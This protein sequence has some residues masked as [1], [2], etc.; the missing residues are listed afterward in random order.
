[1]EKLR[2]WIEEK[3]IIKVPEDVER[4]SYI[5]GFVAGVQDERK[6]VREVLRKVT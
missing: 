3:L 5:K 1:M 4:E 6:R 2:K